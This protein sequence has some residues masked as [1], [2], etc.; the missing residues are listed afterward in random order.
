MTTHATIETGPQT[1]TSLVLS[2]MRRLH[3]GAGYRLRVLPRLHL[4][5]LAVRLLW[6]SL[7]RG[8]WLRHRVLR[9]LHLKLGTL[10]LHQH[11]RAIHLQRLKKLVRLQEARPNIASR[12]LSREWHL[13]LAIL[14]HLSDLIFDND[15]LVDYVLE[16]GVIGVQQL[17]LNVIILPIQEHVLLL[18]ICADV[19]RGI[20]QQLDE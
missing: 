7:Q 13:P 9:P 8:I 4:Y 20:P 18:L 14:L 17:E 10:H 19:V 1:L 6:C 5:A 2:T 16:V 12:G 3:R 11:L 15:G